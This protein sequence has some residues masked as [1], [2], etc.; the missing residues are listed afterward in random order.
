[1]PLPWFHV[2]AVPEP[3]DSVEL[4]DA[5][6]RHATGSRR[7]TS[8]DRVVLFDGRGTVAEAVL[9]ESAPDRKQKRVRAMALARSIALR[10]QPI[11]HLAA[12]LPKGDRQAVMLGMAT[13]LGM[14]SFSPLVCAHGVVEPGPSFADRA[15]R[16][17]LEAC[18][19]CR[20]AYLPR[21]GEPLDPLAVARQ[22][23]SRGDV[24][25][26]A[27]PGGTPVRELTLGPSA[28]PS[29]P[30]ASHVVLIGPEGGFTD[31]EAAL[32]ASQG[33]RVCDLGTTLLRTETAAVAV[34]AWLHL[35]LA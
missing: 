31:D 17:C 15:R 29:P 6:A 34:L 13:Q 1:M 27:H 5:E 24:I 20:C 33:A 8:E 25:W 21:I 19:Q 14:A 18:K 32:V 23:Q 7:L 30:A 28:S 16:V 12:A 35:A 11:L 2:E 26:L 9:A 10:P 4:D 22:S 3:G